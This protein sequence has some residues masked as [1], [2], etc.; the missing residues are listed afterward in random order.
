MESALV[1]ARMNPF[2][3]EEEEKDDD[4]DDDDDDERGKEVGG[5]KW[6]SFRRALANAAEV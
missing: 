6:E 1:N 2:F 4:D 5:K 3:E